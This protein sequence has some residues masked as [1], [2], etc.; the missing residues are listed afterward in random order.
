MVVV[1]AAA[2]DFCGQG[3]DTDGIKQPS[4]TVVICYFMWRPRKIFNYLK[5]EVLRFLLSNVKWWLTEYQFDGFRFD[6]ITSMLYHSHGIGKGYTG[7]YHEYFGPDADI[8]SHI[9]LMLS[10]D[11]IHTIVPSAVTVAEDVSGM[12]TIGLPV[13]W[14][15]FGFDYRLAMAIPDMFIKL[16]KEMGDDNWDMGHIC[17]TLTNRRHLEK[18]RSDF[19]SKLVAWGTSGMAH[20]EPRNDLDAC[21]WVN[22]PGVGLIQI[23]STGAGYRAVSEDSNFAGD[24]RESF[25]LRMPGATDLSTELCGLGEN[26]WPKPSSA[27]SKLWCER[28]E[29]KSSEYF[30]VCFKA[31]TRLR[32]SLADLKCLGP[33]LCTDSASDDAFTRSTSLLGFTHYNYNFQPGGYGGSSS[34]GFRQVFGIR[35][36]QDDGM[37]TLLYT[38]GQPGLE[39]AKG[40]RSEERGEATDALGLF[41]GQRCRDDA[42]FSSA[43]LWESVPFLPGHWI[44]NL[45]T[46]L[47][48]WTQQ[49]SAEEPHCKPSKATL[50]RVI[51]MER[52]GK[53]SLERYSMPFFYEANLETP[54]PCFP[55]KKRTG[56]LDA[57]FYFLFRF[58]DVEIVGKETLSYTSR[59]LKRLRICLPRSLKGCAL[60]PPQVVAYAESHDQA[61]VGDK[62]LAFWLMD[63]AM[64]TDMSIH[65]SPHHS[66][67]VDRGLALHKM[68]RL[69]VLGLG[70]EGYLNFMGNEFGHPEWVDFP[71]PENGWSHHHCRRRFDLPEDDLLRYKFFQNFDELMNALENRF[72]WLSSWHQYV[73]LKHSADKVIVF[74]RGDLLFVFNFHPCNSYDGYQLGCCW[75]EPM[76]TILDTDEGRFG[77]HQRLEYGHGNPFPPMHGAHSRNHSVRAVMAARGMGIKSTKMDW[78]AQNRIPPWMSNI[79][80]GSTQGVAVVLGQSLRPDGKPPQVLLDRALKAKDLLREGKVSR[81]IVTGGDPAGVGRTEAFEMR[82]VLVNAGI[83][84]EVIIQESQAETT[85]ENAW[86]ALRWI[87]RGTGHFYI[88]TSDFHMP[89]ATYIFQEVFNYF[90]RTYEELFKDDPLWKDPVK[91]YPRLV[92]HQAVAQS[93]CGSNASASKDH[94]PQAEAWLPDVDID[95]YSLRKRVLDELGFLGTKEDNNQIWPVQ[96]NVSLDPENEVNFRNALAQ[97]MNTAQ[98]LCICVGPPEVKMYL[99]SRTAQVLV[100]DSLLQGGVK[101]FMD[102][103]FLASYGLPSCEGM[104]LSLQIWKDGK[105]EMMDFDFDESGKVDLGLNFDATFKILDATGQE[106]PC[107]ASKDGFYRV[108]FPG[109]YAICSLG[110]LRNGP[111]SLEGLDSFEDADEAVAEEAEQSPV[112]TK[113]EA[114]AAGTATGTK[115]SISGGYG[116]AG[117]P[118]S[119]AGTAFQERR[120]SPLKWRPAR[121]EHEDGQGWCEWKFGR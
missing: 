75:N 114:V 30:Q 31:C 121:W 37:C 54:D 62:T 32:K 28:F 102:A 10:N 56:G 40:L 92:L 21:Y 68:I 113:A 46:D 91:R 112:A 110:Y 106:V 81:I 15:G 25:N 57:C 87:P 39:Y 6:G 64:Y 119:A 23:P 42:Q 34:D 36:H 93:F 26:K 99:P 17:Y 14:G 8:D 95:D 1:V 4:Q 52:K 43:I 63:A 100:R 44:V 60:F 7:G 27:A 33:F 79:Q 117:W 38:D 72:K 5:Y 18:A 49:R 108:F 78:D 65:Q 109:E 86:Y 116:D 11:L 96:I 22:D 98:A 71:R 58:R 13:E 120:R 2:V 118:S 41:S 80:P 61:I 51:P 115:P 12:P 55:H 104:K 82:K 73:T 50:H 67:A 70:G 89:R 94:D 59:Y 101:I 90:Y 111:G 3:G 16:L 53:G 103:T 76:R 74:E 85:A 88:V 77:G 24:M 35:P 19:R 83:P 105:Q 45:G 48:R 47:F 107:K 84:Q 69:L 20:M 9:Y 66:M 97:I 29:T